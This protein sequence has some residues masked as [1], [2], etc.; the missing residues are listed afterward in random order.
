MTNRPTNEQAAAYVRDFIGDPA[1]YGM[2]GLV[3]TAFVQGEENSV[4]V[5]LEDA[6]GAHRACFSVWFDASGALYGEW[7]EMDDLGQLI[8]AIRRHQ[9]HGRHPMWPQDQVLLLADEIDRLRGSAEHQRAR[10]A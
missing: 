1:D 5:S 4:D 10:E 6:N 2:V 8:E 9:D 7:C 3:M